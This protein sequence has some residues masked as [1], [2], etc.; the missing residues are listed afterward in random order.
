MVSVRATCSA[1]QAAA[2][3]RCT[4]ASPVAIIRRGS[5]PRRRSLCS[6]RLRLPSQASDFGHRVG[7]LVEF[8]E[9]H[10]LGLEEAPR[11]GRDFSS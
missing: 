2:K 4:L 11:S 3:R 1:P 7:D 5:R 8:A 9:G 10:V 6:V